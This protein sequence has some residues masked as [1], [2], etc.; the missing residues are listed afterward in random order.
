MSLSADRFVATCA[1]VAVR[2]A[3]IIANIRWI[4]SAGQQNRQ[5]NDMM[6]DVTRPQPP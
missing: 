1:H 6:P 3:V 2:V 5:L 4:T